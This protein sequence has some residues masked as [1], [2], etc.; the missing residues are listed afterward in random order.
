MK[1]TKLLIFC[2]LFT[3]FTVDGQAQELSITGRVL[4]ENDCL[5]QALPF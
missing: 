1:F 2:F 3:L 4:D 5:Y